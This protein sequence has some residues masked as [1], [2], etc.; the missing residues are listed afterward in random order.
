M[1]TPALLVA[2]DDPVARDLLCEVLSGEGYRVRAAAGGEE[3]V[4]AAEA[5]PFD[6]ALVDLRMPD[7]D[8]LEVLRRLS[9]LKPPVP[10][11]VLTA[12]ATMETAIETIRAG[13]WDYLSKPFRIGEIKLVVA[14]A[15]RLQR[16]LSQ[17]FHVAEQFTGF[18]GKYVKL[19][20]TVES[21]GRV[22]SGEFDH[23]PEQAFYMQ[24]GI[25][26]VVKR[27]EELAKS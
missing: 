1:A 19:E 21:F 20:E 26:D 12:F 27:A 2:D 5:E 15:R 13:A 17:P 22:L 3:C 14:R 7:V 6:L 4:G 23:L 8:G 18:P 25:D 10:V 24:G 9:A 16:F 11:L